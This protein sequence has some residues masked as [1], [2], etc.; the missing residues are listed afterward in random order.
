M[1]TKRQMPTVRLRRLAAELRRLRAGADLTREDVAE[2]TGINTATLYRIETARVRPQRRTLV[3]LLNLYGVRE[4][5]RDEVL[6]LSEGA[7][8]QG[9]LRP[10]HSELPEEYTAYISFEAEARA[11]RNYESLFVPG[12]LQTEDYAR[13]VIK[14]VLPMASA[15]EI[16]QRV[17][18]RVERQ[19]VLV[20]DD[21]LHLWAIMDEAA[22]RRMVGGRDVM[23]KQLQHLTAVAQEPHMT[24]QVIPFGAGAHAG[25]PGS[26]VL[27]SFP[28][29]EDPEIVYIDSMAGDLFLE[30]EADIRRYGAIFDN[31]RAVALSPDDTSN[32]IAALAKETQ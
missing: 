8:V 27:M 26:F 12:L 29:A 6:A 17:Q 23:H 9:W 25:M 21:P 32:L 4:S 30:A 14:G 20:K 24:L 22:L 28:E 13:A 15:R 7:S 11:V 19:A 18:A 16:E 31:L 3:A 10:Y 5:Q 1:P 2:Q